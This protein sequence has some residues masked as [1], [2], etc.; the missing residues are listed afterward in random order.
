M[1][2][3][4]GDHEQVI[5]VTEARGGRRGLHVFW[6]L[7]ISLAL[8]AAALFLAWMWRAGDLASVGGQASAEG[9]AA[10]AALS[11]PQTQPPQPAVSPGSR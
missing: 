9:P 7:L 4:D 10:A 8:A 6:I 3:S 5:S 11:T 1:T 2:M